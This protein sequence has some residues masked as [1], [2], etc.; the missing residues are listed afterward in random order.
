[1]LLPAHVPTMHQAAVPHSSHH[2]E[3]NPPITGAKTNPTSSCC[4]SG[5]NQSQEERTWCY[6]YAMKT[7]SKE[8]GAWTDGQ[9]METTLPKLDGHY[10][11]SWRYKINKGSEEGQIFSVYSF[12]LYIHLLL[13]S[14]SFWFSDL[15]T[16]NFL[17][18]W[19]FFLDMLIPIIPW[20]DNYSF[21]TQLCIWSC[22]AARFHDEWSSWIILVMILLTRYMFV[23]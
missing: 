21:V 15:Q 5:F 14:E 11:I 9:V 19:F 1:M 7:L 8:N 12:S 13:H 23:M 20:T 6:G 3:L 22:K 16:Q 18:T 10:S 17:C 2:D 4:S